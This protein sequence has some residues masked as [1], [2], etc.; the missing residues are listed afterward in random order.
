V[1]YRLFNE[2][3]SILYDIIIQ[4]EDQFSFDKEKNLLN[5]TFYKKRGGV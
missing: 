4:P 1:I 2:L 3:N 5:I